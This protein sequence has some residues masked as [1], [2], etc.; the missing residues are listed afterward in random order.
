MMDSED[1]E[2]TRMMQIYH[3]RAKALK[4]IK[5]EIEGV[6]EDSEYY[7]MPERRLGAMSPDQL[8]YFEQVLAKY[9][10]VKWT[11]VLMHKPLWQR[12][13]DK[14]LGKLEALLSNRPYSVINGHLH[15]FSHQKR[16]GRDYT[17]LG[18]TG[19]GQN[20][21]DSLSFDHITLVRMSDPPTITHL[22]MDGILDETGA[23]PSQQ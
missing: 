7:N 17:I 3:A 4:I 2:E 13:D 6:Y 16:N 8:A 10:T 19:G 14:G 12:E 22:K 21:L 11:F 15:T 18:T 1:F 20:K 23:V 5:G 9:P